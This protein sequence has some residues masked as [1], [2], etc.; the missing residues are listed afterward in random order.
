M[1]EKKGKSALG[2]GIGALLNKVEVDEN[3]IRETHES[4]LE[5]PVGD[6]NP[7]R[8]QPR[9][10]FDEESLAELAQSIREHGI[11]QPLIV[12]KKAKNNYEIVAGERRWRAARLAGLN[13]VPVIVRELA[14]DRIF[15]LALIENLQREDLDPI[16]TAM[17]LQDLIDRQNLTQ[18]QLAEMIGKSRSAIANTLRLLNLPP[19]VRQEI[20]RGEI[21]EGHG[22]ALLALETKE[23]ILACLDEVIAHNLSVRETEALV[24]RRQR[25]G[26]KPVSPAP[27]KDRLRQLTL[28]RIESLLRDE[29][30]TQVKITDRGG[31]GVIQVHYASNEDLERI[32]SLFQLE[33]EI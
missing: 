32:L 10:N 5:I 15:A 13:K 9:K 29:F 2:K 6:I 19:E 24:Q 22:R 20:V 4:V 31:R 27:K 30:M 8:E 23:E 28:K 3:L 16:E 26:E 18:N 12:T 25:Q 11:I 1:T 14:E 33:E 7:N 21:S 17:A